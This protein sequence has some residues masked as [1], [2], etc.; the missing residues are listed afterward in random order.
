MRAGV[1][2]EALMRILALALSLLIATSLTTAGEAQY[3]G[4]PGY[5][6]GYGYPGYG[7]GYGYPGYGYPGYGYGY[8]GYGY[9][10]YGPS[11]GF[12]FGWGGGWHGGGW[13][14]GSWHH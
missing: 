7:Y 8:P 10:Y 14:G 9:P 13:H 1:F 2:E 11:V 6:Y 3:Y 5:G 12:S 4:Y